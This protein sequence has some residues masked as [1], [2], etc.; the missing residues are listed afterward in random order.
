MLGHW[1]IVI[2]PEETVSKLFS[3]ESLS[4]GE[5][6]GSSTLRLYFRGLKFTES[7]VETCQ[8]INRC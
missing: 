7:L 4:L 6:V 1:S 2:N 5:Y 3:L 8:E